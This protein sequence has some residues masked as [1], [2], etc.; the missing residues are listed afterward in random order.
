MTEPSFTFQG[1]EVYR[2]FKGAT[3]I[4]CSLVLWKPLLVGFCFLMGAIVQCLFSLLRYVI[5]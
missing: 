1:T 3:N 5:C 2:G 4:G